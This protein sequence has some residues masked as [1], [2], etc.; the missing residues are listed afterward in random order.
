MK[1]YKKGAQKVSK[2]FRRRKTQEYG[3][4]QHKKLPEQ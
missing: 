2:S 4:D 1:C 3:L